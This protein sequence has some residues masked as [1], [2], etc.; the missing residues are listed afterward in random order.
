[1]QKY[2]QYL[3]PLLVFGLVFILVFRWYSQRTEQLGPE[4]LFGEGVEIEDL[5]DSQEQPAFVLTEDVQT[6]PMEG[7]VDNARG[8]VRYEFTEDGRVRFS[9]TAN[10]PDPEADEYQVWLKEVDGEA[11]RRAFS[12]RINK[13]GYLGSAALPA[14]LLP[15]EILVSNATEVSQVT[16]NVLLR[17]VLEAQ[18]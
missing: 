6:I 13:V 9:V 10:L 7:L 11:M 4:E 1:M 2:T 5:T 3:I 8:E 18:D 16:D 17:A 15:F 12:L 14:D